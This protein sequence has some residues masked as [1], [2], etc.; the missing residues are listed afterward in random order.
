MSS[1]PLRL[2]GGQAGLGVSAVAECT[3]LPGGGHSQRHE[4]ARKL[5]F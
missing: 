1:L 5:S 4:Q 2:A 3:F